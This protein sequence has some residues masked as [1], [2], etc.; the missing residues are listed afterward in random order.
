MVQFKP[1]FMGLEEPPARDDLD[2]ACFRTTD[3]EEVGDATHLTM[4]EMLGNFSI[5]DYFK[6]EAIAWAW[7]FLTG[8]WASTRSGCGPPS[9]ST[10]TRRSRCG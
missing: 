10:T 8:C 5:G 2:P 1:Y 6:A 4:F 9:T 7:E 3:V